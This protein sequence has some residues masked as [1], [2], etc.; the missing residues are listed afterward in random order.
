MGPL[1]EVVLAFN[2]ALNICHQCASQDFSGTVSLPCE[3][4]LQVY[5]N[6]RRRYIEVNSSISMPSTAEQFEQESRDISIISISSTSDNHVQYLQDFNE[7]E[8]T[9]LL[10]YTSCTNNIHDYEPD[11]QGERQQID[12]LG[13]IGINFLPPALIPSPS[14][15]TPGPIVSDATALSLSRRKSIRECQHY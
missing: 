9:E 11:F 8:Q 7:H 2:E 4:V 3:D 6:L 13:D 15:P 1:D 12:L 14:L 10:N 5:Q